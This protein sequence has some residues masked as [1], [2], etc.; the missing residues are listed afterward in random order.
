MN[1]RIGNIQLTFNIGDV[2]IAHGLSGSARRIIIDFRGVVTRKCL[3]TTPNTEL[4]NMVP[5]SL[6]PRHQIRLHELGKA[7]TIET[8]CLWAQ[9]YMPLK[10][11][12]P[13]FL[14]FNTNSLNN[15]QMNNKNKLYAMLLVINRK[16]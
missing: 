14:T 8:R 3:E 15:W 11:S 7:T 1:I 9:K 4:R 2:I 12:R 6:I 10:K 16:T 5:H 13:L